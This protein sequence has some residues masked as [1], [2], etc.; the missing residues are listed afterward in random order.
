MA[1]AAKND[2]WNDAAV[3]AHH[4]AMISLLEKDLGLLQAGCS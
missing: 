4:E 3:Q 2:L 1:L